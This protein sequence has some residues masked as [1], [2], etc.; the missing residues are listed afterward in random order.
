MAADP[1]GTNPGNTPPEQPT[2]NEGS[3]TPN[4]AG[5][6]SA[7][8]S[9]DQHCCQGARDMVSSET[10]GQTYR[11]FEGRGD[12]FTGHIYDYANSRQAADQFTKTTR[13]ICDYVGWTYK[14]RADA[15]TAVETLTHP[16]FTKP[17]DLPVNASQ[18]QVRI[19]EK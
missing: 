15:K 19:W 5:G 6:G 13:E 10:S 17:T 8:G 7:N 2:Q 1:A 12:E 16:A 3:G 18:T 4:Q 14:Y 9:Q 11:K